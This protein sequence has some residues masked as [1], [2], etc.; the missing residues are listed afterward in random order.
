MKKEFSNEEMLIVLLQH[1]KNKRLLTSKEKRIESNL[2]CLSISTSEIE[3][4]FINESLIG[5]HVVS[6]KSSDP[7]VLVLPY[8]SSEGEGLTEKGEI[9]LKETLGFYRKEKIKI[10]ASAF[11]RFVKPILQWVMG[12]IAALIVAYLI[13]KLGWK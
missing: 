9:F 11:Y 7:S 3:Q 12:I 10:K 8:F 2:K 4:T 5:T 13:W 1:A 6:F